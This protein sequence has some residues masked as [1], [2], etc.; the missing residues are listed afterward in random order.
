M[1]CSDW[2]IGV[3]QQTVVRGLLYPL[4]FFESL[5]VSLIN[6][7]G[8]LMMSAKIKS[9]WYKSYVCQWGHQ[10]HFIMWLKSYRK[11]EHVTKGWQL[12]HYYDRSY[13]NHR[14]YYK[15]LTTKTYFF[16]GAHGSSSII[17]DW[18]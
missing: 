2:K 4:L 9:F 7:V 16:L 11:C 3:F 5:K 13:H 8:I 17:W 12:S 15:D 6:M 10:K 14:S 1:G 18:H